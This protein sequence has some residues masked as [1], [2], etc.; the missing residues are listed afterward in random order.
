MKKCP[1]CRAYAT[2]NAA[3]CFECLYSYSHMTSLDDA[4]VGNTIEET[5]K[6]ALGFEVPERPTSSRELVPSDPM[7][8]A[9]DE[10]EPQVVP[11]T[12]RQALAISIETNDTDASITI[13]GVQIHAQR[14]YADAPL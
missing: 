10:R 9:P 3:T 14:E 1:V 13:N 12:Q 7:P 5:V 6:K 2:S 8:G 4:K 11:A